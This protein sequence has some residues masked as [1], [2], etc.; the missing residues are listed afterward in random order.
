[1]A[2]PLRLK[3]YKGDE[4]IATRDFERDHIRIGR[5]ASAH[6]TLEDEKVSRIHTVIEATAD[7]KL[8]ILD[9]GSVEG[10]FV[11]G[12][13]VN[14]K[15]ALAFGDEIKI[16]NT[17]LKVEDVAANL[18][19]A[20]HP[21]AAPGPQ[22][23][24][25]ADAAGSLAQTAQVAATPVVQAAGPATPAAAPLVAA[26]AAPVVTAAPAASPAPVAEPVSAP[27][28]LAPV[29][30]A[31]PEAA[32]P[33]SASRTRTKVKTN[34]PLG[35]SLRFRWGDDQILGEYLLKPSSKRTVFDRSPGQFTVGTAPDVWFNMGDAKL[36][37]PRFVVATANDQ[38]Y[39]LR[40]TKRMVGELERRGEPIPLE[41]LIES[42]K[43]SHDGD[44]YAVSL[45]KDDFAWIDLGGVTLEACFQNVPKPVLV[46]FGE[47]IDYTT[48][49]IFL[50]IFFLGAMFVVA[51]LNRQAA[52][53]VY[54]D[55]L[56]SNDARIAKLI[57]KPPEIQKNPLLQQLA[58]EK[59]K[60]GE[61]PA[62]HSG[63]EGEM[64]KKNA[65]KKNAHAAP[66]G[67]P[68]NKDAARMMAQKIFGKGGAGISTLFSDHN[69][70][71]GELKAAMG[72][73]IGAAAGD[74]GGLEGLGMK[75]GGGGGGG[76][77]HTIGI[78]A[79]GTKGRAGGVS[80]YGN[81]TGIMGGKKSVDIGIT[82]S[83]PVVEGSLDKELIRKVIHS[84]A[85][86]IRFCYESELIKNPKLAGK[87]AVKFVITATGGVATSA[88]VQTTS[89]DSMLDECVSGRVRTWQFPKPKGGGVVVVTYPFI[90][91]A[92]GE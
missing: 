49:N 78:G 1:M 73:M 38:G 39:Q 20:A 59:A 37:T 7:G 33:I 15:G 57:L 54:A 46:P 44:A 79:V 24:A 36:G 68:N 14:N 69:G 62:K 64:G 22:E 51:A 80:G 18:A 25:P 4:L 89:G 17:T 92:S 34:A 58:Q 81:G 63:D 2:Y 55:E 47:T 66:K 12:K 35:L 91:K 9:M 40:F 72:G 31:A 67:D 29:A 83:D 23:A 50:L 65:P 53:D 77:G 26:A 52:G 8:S 90:F 74:S 56:N 60:K 82:S 28:P 42:G 48:L 5:L 88:V 61:A 43:A 11:N 87:V 30:P 6:L 32:A 84:H 86:Q 75:G 45:G 10:T 27:A 41:Q 19:A 3:V 21:E 85:S 71:G 13:R 76:T 16:G 70:L